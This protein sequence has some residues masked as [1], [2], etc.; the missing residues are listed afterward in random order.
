MPRRGTKL[1]PVA[2]ERQ[3]EAIAAYHSEHYENLSLHLKKG[4]RDAWKRLAEARGASMS[5]MIQTYMDGEYQKE[6]GQ[7]IETD[8]K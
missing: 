8:L 7:N 2:A 6:F 4:K 1:S 3:A 5:A